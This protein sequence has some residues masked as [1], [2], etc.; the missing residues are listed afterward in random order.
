MFPNRSYNRP[1]RL[2]KTTIMAFRNLARKGTDQDIENFLYQVTMNYI[3]AVRDTDYVDE[4][5]YLKIS[6]TEFVC[7]CPNCGNE[8]TL[9]LRGD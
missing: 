3:A 5:D 6:D 4:K 8:L 7:T 9:D 2:G 1:N